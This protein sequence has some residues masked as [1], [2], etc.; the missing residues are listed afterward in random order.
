MQL[1]SRKYL[2]PAFAPATAPAPQPH[3][4]HPYFVRVVERT[5]D[6]QNS[7]VEHV[8]VY[9]E[10]VEVFTLAH[11]SLLPRAPTEQYMPAH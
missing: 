11:A 10:L 9:T 4:L 6:P 3:G 1:R 5:A 7:D 8:E 2:A